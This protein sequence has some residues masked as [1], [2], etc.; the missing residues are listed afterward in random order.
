MLVHRRFNL[1]IVLSCQSTQFSAV[2]LQGDFKK[3]LAYISQLGYQGVE[4]AIRNPAQ[5]DYP[6]LYQMLERFSLNVPAIGTG[7]AW[8]EDHLSFTD[9]NMDVREAAIGRVLAHIPSAARLGSKI[10]IGLLRGKTQPGQDRTQVEEWLVDALIRCANAAAERGV[11][12]CI[13]PINRYETDLV[14]N[15]SSGM[16]LVG[17]IGAK[18]LGLLLDTFHM[19]IEEVD[20][21]A[22]IRQA[23]DRLFHFHVADSNRWYPGAGHLDFGGILIT[24]EGIGYTGY[25]SGEFIPLPD[26]D[27]AA[28]RAIDHLRQVVINQEGRGS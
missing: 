24:L 3:N 28:Q 13:E 8:G 19:N 4:L 2:A 11:S 9:P 26:P 27:S 16:E 15:V 18:N 5:I 20:I 17:R 22:S 1:S 7:Q 10:I 21:A 14:N 12:L 23:G 25:V 6:A